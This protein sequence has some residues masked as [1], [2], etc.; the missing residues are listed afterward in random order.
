VSLNFRNRAY[1]TI[2]GN[3][4]LI[5]TVS[6]NN[7]SLQTSTILPMSAIDLTISKSVSPAIVLNGDTVN[8]SIVLQNAPGGATANPAVWRD[9]LPI[10]FDI[11]TV[12][13]VCT[14]SG[15]AVCTPVNYDPFTRVL[16][17]TLTNMPSNSNVIITFKGVALSPYTVTVPTSVRA[18]APC[19]DCVPATNFTQ[20]NFQILGPCDT[21]RAGLDGDT[22][23]CDNSSSTI[24]LY[25]LITGEY[26]G[27]T[28]SRTSGMGGILNSGA[29][30][31]TPA[32]GATT[33]VFMYIKTGISACP[34]DTS[35]ATIIINPTYNITLDSN[36]CAGSS[37]SVCGSV[38]N[39]NGTHVKT[40]TS[41]NGCDSIIT[42]NLTVYPNYN[43]TINATTCDPAQAGTVVQNLTTVDGCDS[44]INTITT[45]LPSY[46]ITVNATTCDPAQVG[47]VVQNLTTIDGCD[48]IITTIT[49]LLPSYNITVNA[50]TCDPAQVGT[51]VQNLTTVDGCDSIVTT[52]T[53]LLPSYNI[54]LNGTTCDPAQAGTVVQNLT[55]VD[56][57]DSIV[58]SITTLLPSYNITVNG[59][60]CDPAQAGTVVQNL[61]ASNGCDSTVT[62]IT[63]LLPSYNITVN[64]QTC[65]PAQAGTVVQNLTTVDGCDSIVTT[66]TTLLPSFD[67]TVNA[68]TCN[69]A[70]AG[71]V[72]QNLLT[73]GG[74]DSTIT[75]ITTLLPKPNAGTDQSVVCFTTDIATMVATGTGTWTLGAGSAGTATITTPTSPTTTVTN[76]SAAGTYLM[77]WL[78][79]GCSDTALI[80]VGSSC[81]CTNPATV[82]FSSDTGHT[83]QN[84]PFGGIIGNYGG[85]ATQA[86]LSHN[87]AGNLVPGVAS[88]TPFNFLYT[89]APADYGNY[90]I[91]NAITDNP[92][93]S[94]CEPDTAIF[95]LKVDDY[96][97]IQGNKV[98]CLGS[99]DSLYITPPRPGTWIS[100]DPNFVSVSSTGVITANQVGSAVIIFN[101]DSF[102]ICSNPSTLITVLGPVLITINLTTCDPAQAGTVVQNLHHSK[103]L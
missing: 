88:S 76:F 47:T 14:P 1:F 63:T 38:Y 73:I 61:T 42:L 15:G 9:T 75:T 71:T 33:S 65:D 79:N 16:T 83:C 49:T 41:I 99:T 35:L 45:L 50:T 90:V 66:I 70:E 68:T 52:I 5:D 39:T 67:I 85:S 77:V 87:G 17:Q 95:V 34:N 29:G 26:G 92:L 43:I 78:N 101:A 37:V 2:P 30:T 27:G 84:V 96:P 58:T 102:T 51:V 55:T 64:A 36:I 20:T 100:S 28:W 44:I 12:S 80:S 13:I 103:W 62:T 18:F 72:V 86:T 10:Q 32:I 91:I 21:V 8:M 94:P 74:C 48:S 46:N 59:T 82:T 97:P 53:T 54:T 11:N 25:S 56:G 3:I 40:C 6:A 31:F 93:G 4:T 57:C 24:D 19:I 98:L 22:I 89:A 7:N 81:G 60:S 69:P 23:I